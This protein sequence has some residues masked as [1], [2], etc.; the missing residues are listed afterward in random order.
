MHFVE[1]SHC[2]IMNCHSCIADWLACNSQV[3]PGCEHPFEPQ[4]KPN[5]EVI[6]LLTSLTTTCAGCDSQLKH[7]EM[8]KHKEECPA[9]YMV[10]PKPK[11]GKRVEK[12]TY[13]KHLLTDCAEKCARCNTEFA[14]ATEH[15]CVQS[16]KAEMEKYKD[17]TNQNIVNANKKEKIN[18]VCNEGHVMEYLLLGEE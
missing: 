6:K 1:C 12:S 9:T 13:D 7:T 18:Q 11:C 14:S 15:D 16:L 3:C 5:L 17:A 10:C 2:M 8:A 4:K